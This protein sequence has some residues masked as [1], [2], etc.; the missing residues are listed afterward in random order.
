MG[1]SLPAH[2]AYVQARFRKEKEAYA[3]FGFVVGMFML[4]YFGE[5]LFGDPVLVSMNMQYIPTFGVMLFAGSL[6]FFLLIR[7]DV[8]SSK[9]MLTDFLYK[10]LFVSS[11]S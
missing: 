4:I 7:S 6:V 3:L 8:K 11:N 5:I 9:I 10:T 2:A 1:S